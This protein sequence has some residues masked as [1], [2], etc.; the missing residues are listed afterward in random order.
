MAGTT[1]GTHMNKHTKL[2]RA[3]WRR[4][5]PV[6]AIGVG[7]TIVV[8]SPADATIF[9]RFD[10]ADT[11]QDEFPICGVDINYAEE[12]SGKGHVREGKGRQAGAFF[13]HDNFSSSQTFT[14]PDNGN[15]FTISRDGIFKEIK[16]TPVQGD[17]FEFVDH[18]AGQPFVLRDM[19]GNVLVRDRGLISITYLFDTG[20]DDVPGGE[21]IELLDV[22][23]SG[24]HPGFFVEDGDECPLVRD[25]LLS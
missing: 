7:M 22:R 17:V 2:I 25:L 6:V 10:Y 20:G 3:S 16:A 24:P 5:L 18:E 12:F 9:E 4:M 8:S 19:D 15:F 1:R 21:F 13:V 14:N 23:V 11:V